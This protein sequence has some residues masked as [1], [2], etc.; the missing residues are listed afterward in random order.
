MQDKRWGADK[1]D[2]AVM[3]SRGRSG[4]ADAELDYNHQQARWGRT[5]TR[6]MS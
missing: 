3:K 4:F 6:W 1:L 2:C 5:G